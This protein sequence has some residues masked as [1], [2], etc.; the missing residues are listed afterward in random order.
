VKGC[1]AVGACLVRID[2]EVVVN[3]NLLMSPN[4]FSRL[5]LDTVQ[6]VTLRDEAHLKGPIR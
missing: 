1:I 3:L 6:V 4:E 5:A 2:I